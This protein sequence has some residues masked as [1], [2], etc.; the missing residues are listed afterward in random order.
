[1]TSTSVP[2]STE[3]EEG[4]LMED[5]GGATNTSGG[6][7]GGGEA[8]AQP[9]ASTRGEGSGAAARAGSGEKAQPEPPSKAAEK[10]AGP[11]VGPDAGMEAGEI[12]PDESDRHKQPPLRTSA[13]DDAKTKPSGGG[14]GSGSSSGSHFASKTASSG[15]DRGRERE[16]LR[17]YP[18]GH[19]DTF[20]YL[21]PYDGRD[22]GQYPP[23]QDA[24]GEMAG[25]GYVDW[26]RER[27]RRERRYPGADGRH[28]GGHY[29]ERDRDVYRERD[30]Y[31]DSRERD[32]GDKDA[33]RYRYRDSR[34][35]DGDS[36]ARYRDSDRDRDNDRERYFARESQN[37]D[38]ARAIERERDVKTHPDTRVRDA[39]WDRNGGKRNYADRKVS[40]ERH[41]DIKEETTD[42]QRNS[43][44]RSSNKHITVIQLSGN[45]DNYQRPQVNS[46]VSAMSNVTD[47]T[48][49]HPKAPSRNAGVSQDKLWADELPAQPGST[50]ENPFLTAQHDE[51]INDDRGS[52]L[53]D[54][55]S[56][57]SKSPYHVKRCGF[58]PLPLPKMHRTSDQTTVPIKGMNNWKLFIDGNVRRYR[59][60]GVFTAGDKPIVSMDPRDPTTA[61]KPFHWNSY[62]VPN[63]IVDANTV[64]PPTSVPSQLI[65]PQAHS[66]SPP[67]TTL[68]PQPPIKQQSPEKETSLSADA[69]A[70]NSSPPLSTNSPLQ[71]DSKLLF[72]SNIP[73][74]VDSVLLKTHFAL[75]GELELA[76]AH[77]GIGQVKYSS[78]L[79]AVHVLQNP[80]MKI[81]NSI[82]ISVQADPTGMLMKKAVAKMTE[83]MDSQVP[84]AKEI[85]L[86]SNPPVAQPLCIPHKET[87]Q[88]PAPPTSNSLPK[89]ILDFNDE[90]PWLT[91]NE[92]L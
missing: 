76:F 75:Y 33:D 5:G 31:G 24:V 80:T 3:V 74:T 7:G 72:I 66:S 56:S 12:Q 55:T 43:R 64:S 70:A 89:K 26:Y 23:Y 51:E 20:E 54:R 47:M 45:G 10:E 68:P 30:K 18:P 49:S 19:E 50:T 17:D 59:V 65:Q 28:Q 14:S 34:D 48:K 21:F 63:F 87:H 78:N 52:A 62:I 15:A 71:E 32:R 8:A 42:V 69:E 84:E 44:S 83:I 58:Q 91:V 46:R 41:T 13:T 11:K 29:N 22:G 88:E 4:E 73:A 77:M 82:P 35:R 38:Q 16:D 37:R 40:E 57:N 25:W 2:G 67:P 53:R 1:M 6:G 9:P 27:Q 36:R 79:S 81:N 61:T 92:I 85:P 86:T 39:E 60:N 90:D